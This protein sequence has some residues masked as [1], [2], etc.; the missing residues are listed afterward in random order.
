MTDDRPALGCLY[1]IGVGPGVDIWRNS[2]RGRNR[3]SCRRP[4]VCGQGLRAGNSRCFVRESYLRR[5]RRR[6]VRDRGP[7][8]KNRCQNHYI[9]ECV[10]PDSLSFISRNVR[11]HIYCTYGALICIGLLALEESLAAHFGPWDP[12]LYR[13]LQA[14]AVKWPFYLDA[15]RE[16]ATSRRRKV[17]GGGVYQQVSAVIRILTM[18]AVVCGAAS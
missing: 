5:D 7:R 4:F 16:D 15:G 11:G 12:R 14:I 9:G 2:K 3:I 13:A 8:A 18:S 10:N 1:G 6:R 17:A